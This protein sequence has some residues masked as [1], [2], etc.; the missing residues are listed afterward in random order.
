MHRNASRHRRSPRGIGPGVEVGGEVEREQFAIA[1]AA[2][3]QTHSCRMALRS[4]DYRFGAR[5]DHAHGSS[6]MPRGERQEWLNGQVELRAK[7]PADC[8]RND[9][10][11]VRRNSQDRRDVAAIHV[12]RLRARLNLDTIANPACKPSLRFNVSVL[13][14]AGLEIAFDNDIPTRGLIDAHLRA[15]GVRV[16]IVMAYDNIET[17]KNRVEIG[18]GIA[19]VPED[20]VLQEARAGQL[21]VIP[22]AAE[23]TFKRP[24][25]LLLK[26]SKV[27]RAA[28]RAF[29]EAMRYEV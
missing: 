11:L 16:R 3:A 8:G 17:L 10:H 29:T 15:A 24:A 28:V 7:P 14:K 19:L 1:T 20:T 22:L 21:A 18:S 13:D 27:R 6:Q 4:R 9:P 23:D 26:S 5:I 12:R 25:G 2:G